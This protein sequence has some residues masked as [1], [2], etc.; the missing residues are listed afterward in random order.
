VVLD[1]LV[2]PLEVLFEAPGQPAYPLPSSLRRAYG[3]GLGFAGPIVYANFVTTLDGVAAIDDLP[4]VG[5]LIS[6][7]SEGDRFTMGLLRACADTVLIGA[8]T[9][10]A[11]P[12]SLWTA[13][14]AFPDAA[15]DFA[16]L[17]RRLGRPRHPQLAILSGSG[18]LKL[19]HPGLAPGALILTTEAGRRRLPGQLPP[20]VEVAVLGG[21]QVDVARLRSALLGRGQGVVLSEAGPNLMGQMLGQLLVDELFLTMSPLIAGEPPGSR[22][23]GFSAGARLL[24]ERQEAA[25]LVSVRRGDDHLFLRY[26]LASSAPA[27]KLPAAAEPTSG[28]GAGPQAR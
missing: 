28:G 7:G 26:R 12:D 1:G 15:A 5:Q 3:G 19:D 11:S 8:G 9:L 6:G 24:P 14:A 17:R 13:D 27:G 21:S 20:G 22:R 18:M 23:P 2:R 25:R 16:L 10:R 4:H